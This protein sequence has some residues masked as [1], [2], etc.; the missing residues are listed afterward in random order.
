[1]WEGWAIHGWPV[2]TILRGKVVVDNGTLLG[3]PGDGRLIGGRKTAAA[4]LRGPAC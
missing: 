2:R 3:D 1:V 4:V